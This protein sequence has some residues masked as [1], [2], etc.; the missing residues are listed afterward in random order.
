MRTPQP[1]QGLHADPHW[2]IYMPKDQRPRDTP[3][4]ADYST[5][6]ESGRLH[7]AYVSTGANNIITEKH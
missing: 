3:R 4:V 2:A 5:G 7:H 1:M 6:G